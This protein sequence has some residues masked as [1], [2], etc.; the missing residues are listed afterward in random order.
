MANIKTIDKNRR[1]EV[2]KNEHS[3]NMFY[4]MCVMSSHVYFQLNDN[5]YGLDLYFEIRM[6]IFREKKLVYPFP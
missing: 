5:L 6:I 1:I 3:Y 4:F 2:I